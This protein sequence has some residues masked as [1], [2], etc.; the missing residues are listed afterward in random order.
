LPRLAGMSAQSV[1]KPDE[2][3]VKAPPG[4]AVAA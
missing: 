3:T 4:E 2:T 1:A